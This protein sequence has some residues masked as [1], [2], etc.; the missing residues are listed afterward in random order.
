MRDRVLFKNSEANYMTLPEYTESIPEKHKEK[1]KGKVVYFEDH[2][3]DESLRTQ[4][5]EEG[6]HAITTEAYIDPHFTQHVEM[7]KKNDI[8]IKFQLVDNAIE[9]VLETQNATEDD[10][11]IKD[12]FQ[13]I[14]V[15]IKDE[16]N[17]SQMEIE[18]KNFKNSKT[19]AYFKVDES[20]KRFQQMTKSM[21]QSNFDM[22]SKKTLVLNPSYNLVKNAFKLSESTEKKELAGKICHHIQDLAAISG[23]GLNDQQ[24]KD[25]VSRSQDLMSEL[26]NL[27]L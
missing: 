14:L 8:E 13:D 15:G 5:L 21:G 20:M 7:Q 19:A 10:V 18:V 2:A 4:L 27:A 1:L 3:S 25:F 9:D 12:L 6:I 16:K 17:P 23:E 22:P 24:R 11:K 26:S